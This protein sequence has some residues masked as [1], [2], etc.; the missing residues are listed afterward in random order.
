MQQT[1]TLPEIKLI[2]IKART[3]NASELNPN[4]S[5]IETTAL[6]YL[7]NKLWEKIIH[8]KK[9]GT[10]YCV[11]TDYASDFTGDYT[12]FIGEEVTT[13]TLGDLPEEFS[14]LTISPQTYIKFTSNPGVIPEIVVN[15]WQKTW[16]MSPE[17]LGGNRNYQTD[18]EIYDARAR[19]P[20]NAVFDLY[21]GI[22]P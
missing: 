2:G 22:K 18:F 16:K 12:Y 13:F 7:H 15:L 19:N 9:P 6:K 1:I 21:I 3:N 4:T 20:Q 10:T 14:Q 5:K 11:Y 8:R 17:E